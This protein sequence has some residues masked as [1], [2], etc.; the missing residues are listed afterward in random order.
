[1]KFLVFLYFDRILENLHSTPEKK[2]NQDKTEILSMESKRLYY[3]IDKFKTMDKL[4]ASV[5]S[6][7][8][9]G[10]LR[11]VIFRPRNSSRKVFRNMI[12]E[13]RDFMMNS[14]ILRGLD[15]K[16][17]LSKVQNIRNLLLV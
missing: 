17:D 16:N 1:M 2:I 11:I 13:F 3:R 15:F 8:S 5:S 10:Q 6:L 4:N 12:L 14:L 9:E 7:K